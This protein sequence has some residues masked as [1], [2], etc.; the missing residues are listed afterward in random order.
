MTT[1]DAHS[2]SD[3]DYRHLNATLN[4][5]LGS[6]RRGN[7]PA[8]SQAAVDIAHRFAPLFRSFWSQ[9]AG[10]PYED[11]VQEVMLR[12]FI[13]LQRDIDIEALPGLLKRIVVGVSADYWRSQHRHEDGREPIDP[14]DLEIAFEESFSPGIAISVLADSLPARERQVIEMHFVA[15][16]DTD[17]IASALGISEGAVRMTKARALRRLQGHFGLKGKNFGRNDAF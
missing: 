3:I 1:G 15:D 16:M 10:G 14:A 13:A 7:E 6:I 5:L 12:L 11:F 4:A 2:V 8:A 17:E 9:K